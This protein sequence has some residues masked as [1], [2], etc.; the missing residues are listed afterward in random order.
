MTI[1]LVELD[2]R[3]LAVVHL[4]DER[5]ARDAEGSHSE[6]YRLIKTNFE[7]YREAIQPGG[8]LFDH[9]G[10]GYGLGA[11]RAVS[12]SLW[13][14]EQMCVTVSHA[15]EYFRAGSDGSR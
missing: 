8:T 3:L 15:E 14:D 6:M 5:L 2:A 9:V 13:N 1:D 12:D 7:G 4:A 10:T 11:Y